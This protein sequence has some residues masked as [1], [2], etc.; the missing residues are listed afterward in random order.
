MYE[1]RPKERRQHKAR[2]AFPVRDS[3][4]ELVRRERRV[5]ADRR[6]CD[7]Q[8]ELDDPVSCAEHPPARKAFLCRVVGR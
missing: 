7:I 6:L 3:N 8:A 5:L 1:R 4:G 2:T